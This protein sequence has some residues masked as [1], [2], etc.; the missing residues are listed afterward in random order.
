MGLLLAAALGLAACTGQA[1]ATDW[2][3][4][5]LHGEVALIAH[6]PQI[7]AL[8]TETSQTVWTFPTTANNITGPFYVE[9]G[10]SDEV[11]VVGSEGPAGS[12]SGLVYGLDLDG[13]QRWCAAFDAAGA[14]RSGCPN[15]DGAET[16]GIFSFATRV[17]NRVSSGIALTDGVA[18]FGLASGQVFAINASGS[19]GGTKLWSFKAGRSVWATPLVAED[20]VYVVSLDHHLYAL[21]RDTGEPRWQKDLGAAIA[22]TPALAEGLLYVGAFDKALHVLDADSGEEQWSFPTANW[23]WGGPVIRDGIVYFTD[24]SGN[25]FAVNLATHEK[26][27]AVKPGGVIRVSPV[28][29]GDTLYVGDYDGRL[30]ALNRSNGA[31]KWGDADKVKMR[32]RLLTTPLVLNDKILVTPFQGDNLIA[33]YNT[34]DGGPTSLAWKPSK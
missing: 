20:T 1:Q 30:M 5:A 4:L 22:G 19:T 26:I 23:I 32:G 9:P 29:A 28:L 17:D 27:W 7:Y 6:G 18:Y 11:I 8:D 21:N 25:V 33:G 12:Y 10:V 14:Q 13:N 3:G 15:V 16:S 2:P 34:S 24:I 31:L